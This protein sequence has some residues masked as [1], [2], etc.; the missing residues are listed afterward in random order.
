LSERDPERVLKE[1]A[2]EA[3]DP[4][5]LLPG[6]EHD[7]GSPYVE[8]AEHWLAVYDELLQ[9]KEALISNLTAMMVGKSEDA[10]E[11][12]ASHD[13]LILKAQ[14]SRFKA[15]KQYWDGARRSLGSGS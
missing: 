15:R 5:T 7:L 6:E 14:V 10:L 1:K 9:T 2:Q 12:M 13:L 3:V 11:E 4:D 8:D